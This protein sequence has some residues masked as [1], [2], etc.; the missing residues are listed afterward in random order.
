MA[1]EATTH[2]HEL[3]EVSRSAFARSS[4]PLVVYVSDNGIGIPP[5]DREEVF[6]VFRRLHSTP[7]YG[8]GSGAGL[9]IVRRIVER[10]GGSVWIEDS[11]EGGSRVCFTVEP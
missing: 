5:E 9:A 7:E 11:E 1:L 8:P 3:P 2:G 6:R 4:A 10:H